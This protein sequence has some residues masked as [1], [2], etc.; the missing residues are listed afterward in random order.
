MVESLAQAL[1]DRDEALRQLKSNLQKAQNLMKQTSDKHR[2]NVNYSVGDWVYVKLR[3]HR[4]S[5]VSKTIY[6]KLTAR[7]YG[8]FQIEARIGEVAYRLI[9]PSTSRIHPV[10]HVSQLKKAIGELPAEKEL[11]PEWEFDVVPR[12]EPEAVLSARE[13]SKNGKRIEEW[14]IRWKGR[15][16]EDA[17]WERAVNIKTQFPTFCLEDKAVFAEEGIDRNDNPVHNEEIQIRPKP[18]IF[19]VYSRRSKK[20]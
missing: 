19:K 1:V 20:N 8:H 12:V 2:R 11:P 15:P 6:S 14:L 18:N 9:L 16:I 4:Q 5:S 3:P 7:Y 10:F 13:V 17:T